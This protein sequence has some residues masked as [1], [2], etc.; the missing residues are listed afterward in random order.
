MSTIQGVPAGPVKNSGRSS[1]HKLF[2]YKRSNRSSEGRRRAVE[3]RPASLGLIMVARDEID[4]IRTNLQFHYK[5]GF[6]HFLVMDNASID[7]TREELE[8]LA[9]ELP[10]TVIDQPDVSFRQSRWATQLAEVLRSNGIDWGIHLDADEFVSVKDGSLKNTVSGFDTPIRCR[11]ENVLPLASYCWTPSY[12]PLEHS[13]LRVVRPFGRYAFD[14]GPKPDLPL[15]FRTLPGKVL[16][17]LR[18]LLKVREGNHRVDHQKQSKRAPEGV[19]IRHFPA[20]G[21]AQFMRRLD[22]WEQRFEKNPPPAS[23]SVHVRHWLE[24]RRHGLIEAEYRK[25]FIPEEKMQAY[26][27]DGTIV[28]DSFHERL[29]EFMTAA[30]SDED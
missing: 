18:G 19:L 7:G 27:E 16:F 3:G 1:W 8:K 21:F 5:Q 6:D 14:G 28:R 30:A 25:F 29:A 26:L 11:R 2:K 17:P 22:H 23:I 24:L 4:Y 9:R 12:H 10:L 20:R 13:R 15:S